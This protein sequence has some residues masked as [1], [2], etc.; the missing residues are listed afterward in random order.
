MSQIDRIVLGSI[1]ILFGW[2]AGAVAGDRVGGAVI[3]TIHEEMSRR[4]GELVEQFQGRGSQ[5][6]EHFGPRDLPRPLISI[7]L[8]HR[9]ELALTPAQVQAL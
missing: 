9:D 5:V 8:S 1:L 6:R 2:T 7:L 4:L 3:P